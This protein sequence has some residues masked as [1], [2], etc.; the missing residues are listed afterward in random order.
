[1][2]SSK[3]YLEH[4][5]L[6]LHLQK[7]VNISSGSFNIEGVKEV[8]NY[9]IEILQRH[10][11]L[12]KAE[13]SHQ[14][15]QNK[16]QQSSLLH[17]YG[18]RKSNPRAR[19]LFCGHADT[20]FERSNSFKGVKKL[21]EFHWT[22]PGILDMKVG[23]LMAVSLIIEL[24]G[25]QDSDL[26][27]DLVITGDEELGSPLSQGYL[28]KIAN[29][30]DLGLVFEPSFEDG[31]LASS[32]MGSAYLQVEVTGKPAHVGRNFHEGRNAIT[33]ICQFASWIDQQQSQNLILNLG[34]IKGGEK[35]NIVAQHAYLKANI[36][37][38]EHNDFKKLIKAINDQ[39]LIYQAQNQVQIQLSHHISRPPRTLNRRQKALHTQ[40]MEIAK[41]LNISLSWRATGGV[42]DGNN[43]AAAG[44]VVLDN[45]GAQGW[46]IHTQE[47]TLQITSIE[48]RLRLLSKLLDS[49]E[50]IV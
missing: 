11:C 13:V 19:I 42:C 44:L 5:E 10:S 22:G 34:T 37:F 49:F 31:A 12:E 28:E 1:M 4:K 36:R 45:I 17:I 38:A 35:L 32:R 15:L 27:W 41:L 50:K 29:N 43:L 6:L 24:S 8:Q 30:Y 23:L 39:V 2:T 40:L 14:Y 47:E 33:T 7:L 26:Q 16:E 9:C 48:P 21:D 3:G 46:G 20:V 25:R 18:P